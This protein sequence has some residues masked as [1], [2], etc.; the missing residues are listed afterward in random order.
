MKKRLIVV[1]GRKVLE[2]KEKFYTLK[3]ANGRL[4]ALFILN[5]SD[6]GLNM[7]SLTNCIQVI[8]IDKEKVGSDKIESVLSILGDHFGGNTSVL[9]FPRRYADDNALAYE[10]V[11]TLGVLDLNYISKFLGFMEG[12]T[13]SPLHL[14]KK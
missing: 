2:E 7:S 11:Y 1:T 5:F 14:A 3:T 6:V 8:V 12:L 10:N 9:L 4:A 13:K